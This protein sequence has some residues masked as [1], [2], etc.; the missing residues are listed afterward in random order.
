MKK[1]RVWKAWNNETPSSYS[2]RACS[3]KSDIWI[4]RQ[5]LL[6]C[7]IMQKRKVLEAYDLGHVEWKLYTNVTKNFI[8]LRS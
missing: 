4:E 7:I 2:K 3:E 1:E 8:D 5:R 6:H